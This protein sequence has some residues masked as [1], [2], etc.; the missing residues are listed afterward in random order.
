MLKVFVVLRSKEMLKKLFTKAV[1]H[2][3]SS[4]NV[5][6]LLYLGYLFGKMEFPEEL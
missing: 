4:K 6:I 2:T 3:I 5:N 1:V